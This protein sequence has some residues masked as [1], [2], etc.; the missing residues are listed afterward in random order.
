MDPPR[1]HVLRVVR[2]ILYH[3][4]QGRRTDT[5]KA[6]DVVNHVL[7]RRAIVFLI[8]DFQSPGDAVKT[9]SD[10]LAALG[11]WLGWQAILP[12]ILIGALALVWFWVT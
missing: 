8:S 9:R 10:L 2:D 4:P 5:V 11:A 3:T 7:H 6:L 12:I 1:R